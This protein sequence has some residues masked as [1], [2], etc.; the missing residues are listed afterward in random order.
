[1][2]RRGGT[3]RLLRWLWTSRRIDARLARVAL[4]PAAALWRAGTRAHEAALARG[5]LASEELPLPAIGVGN[6]T[7]GGSGR[8]A[9][10]L[11]AARAL[12]ERGERP[13]LVLRGT[14]AD[15][16]A[17]RHGAPGAIVVAAPELAR[18]AARAAAE[19]AT[20]LLLDGASGRPDLPL[21]LGLAVVSAETSRAVRWPVPAGPWRESLGTLGRAHA[22][23]VTRKRA[24][25]EVAEALAQ[26]LGARFDGPVAIAH[27]GLRELEGLV[28]GRR[29]PAALL[30]GRRVVAAAA[31]ADPDA[32]VAQAKAAGAA[33]QVHTWRD[34]HEFRDEDVAWL[35][36]AA[37][38]ADH[39]VLTERDA[40]R[41]RD[42]WPAAVPEPLVAVIEPEWE[43]G[44][45]AVLAALAAAVTPV[46]RL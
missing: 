30:A 40:A 2:P 12:V 24:P 34:G 9:I 19:G 23:V 44:G 28:S 27:L 5:W 37:R 31:S 3:H 29:Q 10:A 36:H 42:R 1:M 16:E 32:F 35:A 6:L 22:L 41:L 33:V 20:V 11:W 39:V 18:G 46:E 26:E 43:L 8:R 15:A 25:R 38:R 17:A 21:D 13:G 4:L 45:D 7:V 14:T